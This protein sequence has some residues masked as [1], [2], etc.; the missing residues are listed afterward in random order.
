[1]PHNMD[2]VFGSLQ[3][4]Q[5]K[6]HGLINNSNLTV[7]RIKYGASDS[8]HMFVGMYNLSTKPSSLDDGLVARLAISTTLLQ[9]ECYVI[10]AF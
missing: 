5:R 6:C 8:C 10:K 7:T 1:M 3:F 2:Y 4:M 9:N